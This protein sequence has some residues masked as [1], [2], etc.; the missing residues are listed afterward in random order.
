[1]IKDIIEGWAKQIAEGLMTEEERELA[2][3]RIETCIECEHFTPVKSCTQCGCYM[4]AKTKVVNAN[5]PLK[6]W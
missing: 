5:C 1:M 4:P 3:S 2:Q 6:K